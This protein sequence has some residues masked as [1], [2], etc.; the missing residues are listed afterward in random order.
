MLLN[1]S[2]ERA[3]PGQLI[4]LPLGVIAPRKFDKRIFA[5]LFNF[6]DEDQWSAFKQASPYIRSY[7]YADLMFRHMRQIMD[8]KLTPDPI[9]WQVARQSSRY[10]LYLLHLEASQA[11]E[12]MS[13][14]GPALDRLMDAISLNPEAEWKVEDMAKQ[15]YLSIP[16]FHVIFRERYQLTPAA[17]VTEQR[18]WRAGELLLD[19][20][21]PIERIAESVGYKSYSSFSRLFKKFLGISPGAYRREKRRERALNDASIHESGF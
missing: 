7:E 2:W 18:M 5:I 11:I 13:S 19:T 3:Y 17:A 10:L 6:N 16:Q 20:D 4:G 14:H 21:E 12:G 8:A 1:G 15:L 9:R